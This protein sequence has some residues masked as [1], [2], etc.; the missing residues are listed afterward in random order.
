MAEGEP[1]PPLPGSPGTGPAVPRRVR[2]VCLCLPMTALSLGGG[3]LATPEGHSQ[4]A[5]VAPQ[6]GC[7]LPWAPE[8]PQGL[9]LVVGWA[10]GCQGSGYSPA[11]GAACQALS[12][13]AQGVWVPRQLGFPSWKCL[14]R[15]P[16]ISPS[17]T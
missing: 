7:R 16:G 13:W 14:I 1:M 17:L 9:A 8:A 6:W 10:F 15:L 4:E 2:N 11:P 5:S 12:S 3:P